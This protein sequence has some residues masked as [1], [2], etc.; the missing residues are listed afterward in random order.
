MN[1]IFL[2]G[3][4]ILDKLNFRGKFTLIGIIMFGVITILSTAIILTMLGNIHAVQHERQGMA[5]I[6]KV[7]PILDAVQRHRGLNNAYLSG[8]T[9]ALAKLQEINASQENLIAAL[10]S[11][12]NM[13]MF[14][15]DKQWTAI[16]TSWHE[17][18]DHSSSYTKSQ[19]FDEHTRL[20]S[21]IQSMIVDLADAS[22]VTL[23]SE[24]GSYY[25]QDTVL[26]KLLALTESIGKL[27]AKGTGILAAQ[28]SS[29][30]ERAEVALLSGTMVSYDQAVR[31]N[32]AKATAEHPRLKIELAASAEKISSL[33]TSLQ[34]TV[35]NEALIETPSMSP[36][37]FFAQATDTINAA[38][39]LY[40]QADQAFGNILTEREANLKKK[41]AL[42][43]AG[44][45]I[46]LLLA[47]YF[48]LAMSASTSFAVN[49][50]ETIASAFSQGD[51]TRRIKLS[52]K[53]E[54]GQIAS[55]FNRAG[56]NLRDIMVSVEQSTRSV[57]SSAAALQLSSRQI[58][59]AS[60]Q[61]SESIQS[62]AAGI[63][64]ITVS[65][66]H[67]ADSSR[68]ASA[69]A[70]AAAETSEVG[71]KTVHQATDEMNSIASSVSQS[72][73]LI[74]GLNERARQ[75]SSIAGVIRDIADQTNLL[76][77]NAAIEAARAGEQG[78][79]FAVVADEVRK[80]AERTGNA[81]GEITTMI[82]DI[83]RETA[84]AVSSM[85]TGS[86]QANRGVSL[87]KE[88]AN[89]LA[90]V[91]TG[92]HDSRARIE[93]IADAM[94]EQ[95]AATTNIAQNLERISQMSENANYEVQNTMQS[96]AEL[97]KM[98]ARL[99]EQVA[100]FKV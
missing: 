94:R 20:V 72:A 54:M 69:A 24:M 60:A 26:I 38:Q 27:R 12:D 87:A 73:A 81:T 3:A 18:R 63:E 98:A 61:Q 74:N 58:A 47:I 68:E 4:A 59:N 79:G 91:N 75:I 33:I 96:I 6:A 19:S 50:I 53:D 39:A 100:S 83:Q 71:E 80:L 43:L 28:T 84:N 31:Q 65:I 82:G 40:K 41:M 21:T 7:T 15:T 78:R 67:V 97:E 46:P 62:T 16:K 8:D 86:A 57:F 22:G 95:S 64:E 11:D 2:P 9:L 89:A 10:D 85:E 35:K 1:G 90:Q 92:S 34:K 30:E 23:D 49:E 29:P 55:S 93:E 99:Q 32:L 14:G 51:L 66:S 76:A 37:T 45:T 13:H 5:T 25:L 88:A 77:L 52:S 36:T 42:Y 48:F 44:G 70:T 56:D 17:I